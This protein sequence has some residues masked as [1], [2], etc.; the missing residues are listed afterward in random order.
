MFKEFNNLC[1]RSIFRFTSSEQGTW[2]WWEL[3]SV[4]LNKMLSFMDKRWQC[5]VYPQQKND[6][7]TLP[8]HADITARQTF[9]RTV[10]MGK[11]VW[12][13]SGT[14]WFDGRTWAGSEGKKHKESVGTKKGE[15]TYYDVL[16][17]PFRVMQLNPYEKNNKPCNFQL[18]KIVQKHSAYGSSEFPLTLISFHHNRMFGN[19]LFK[20]FNIFN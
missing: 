16:I 15:R 2:E 7:L 18:K 4:E 10:L 19:D 13:K 9:P 12:G 6:Y 20:K 1:I 5:N 14:V 17:D 3:C 8:T 11:L